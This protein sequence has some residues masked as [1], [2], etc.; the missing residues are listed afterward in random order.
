MPTPRSS[1]LSMKLFVPLFQY[2]F[3]YASRLTNQ[4]SHGAQSLAQFLICI[5]T[6]RKNT[7][8]LHENLLSSKLQLVGTAGFEPLQGATRDNSVPNRV[9]Y[10]AALRPLNG[11]VGKDLNLRVP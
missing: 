1:E 10:Q 4:C 2:R 6:G 7:V 3:S 5:G 11:G 8:D 9:R